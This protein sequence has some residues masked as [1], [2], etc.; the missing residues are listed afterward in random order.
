MSYVIKIMGYADD[1]PSP[2][3]GRYVKD[4][5]PDG[6]GGQGL[7][8]TTENPRE[9]LQFPNPTRACDL[10][11]SRSTVRPYRQDGGPNRPMSAFHIEIESIDGGLGGQIEARSHR[12]GVA[13]H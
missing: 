4:Y 12:S 2:Y 9:A 1:Q 10:Y 13:L 8:D 7:I 11:Q 3:D 5:D 6:F